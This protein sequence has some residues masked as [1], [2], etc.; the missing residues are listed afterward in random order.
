MRR[1]HLLLAASAALVTALA[2]IAGAGA[3]AKTAVVV[4]K[5]GTAKG[6]IAPY[7]EAAKG[8]REVLEPAAEVLLTPQTSKQAAD[9]VRAQVP[10]LLVAFGHEAAVFAARNF[11]DVPRVVALAPGIDAASQEGRIAVISPDVSAD[12]QVRW[13]ADALPDVRK[14]GV[15]FDP[16][17]SQ[18]RIDELVAAA[19]ARDGGNL[20]IV[21]LFVSSEGEVPA[22]FRKAVREKAIDALLFVP[23]RTVI[24][25]GTISHLMKE[26]LAASIPTIG[27][28][29]YLV[30]NGAVL[31]FGLDY[32]AVGRQAADVARVLPDRTENLVAEPGKV[33]IWVNRR[34]ADKLRIRTA[35]DPDKVQEIR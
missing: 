5:A 30:D 8:F 13:I 34:V 17:A 32:A 31:G 20:E 33:T 14:V 12:V 6:P 1:R 3:E 11:P 15:L 29:W 10:R 18:S 2:P 25:R 9:A 4:I 21:P 27:F 19:R 35:Y 23:D 28:N 7:E 22:A 26:S 16:A 24:T